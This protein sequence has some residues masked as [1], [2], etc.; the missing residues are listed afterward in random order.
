ML[1]GIPLGGTGRVMGDGGG[2]AEAIAYLCLDF[3]FPGPGGA[4]V[5]TA[6][7]G[8]DQES[9]RTTVT[10]GSIAFPPGGDGMGGE[11]R[12]VMRDADTDRAR[13]L[14]GS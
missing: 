10:T 11:G 5:A 2:D 6:G 3:R 12:S 7:V 9:G 13:L 8:Q 4:A 1:D 14:G